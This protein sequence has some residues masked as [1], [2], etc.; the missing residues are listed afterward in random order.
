[1]ASNKYRYPPAPPN[2]DGTFSDNL[3]GFQVVDGGGLTQGNFEFTS[4][5]VQK[6]NRKFETGV[7]QKPLSLSDLNINS[8]L[9]AKRLVAKN[10]KVF[11][12]FDVSEVTS[13]ALYGSLQKRLSTS[14]TKIINYFP[15]AL[16]IDEIG[17]DLSTGY[18]A[19]DILFDNVENTTTFKIDVNRFKNPFDIDYSENADRNIELRPYEVSKYRN[20]TKNYLDYA[21]YFKEFSEEYKF[22][23]FNASSSLYSS[24]VEIT[25]N[26]NPFSGQTTSTDTILL[27]P[28]NQNTQYSFSEYFDEVENFLLSRKNTPIYTA[29]FQV[30]K[31]NENGKLYNSTESV[32]FPKDGYWNLDIVTERF[33]RYIVKLNQISEELDNF[34]TNLISRFLVT[35]SFK[36]FDTQDQR[37]ESVLQL[38]GR[39]FDETKKFIDALANMNSVNYITGND[40]PSQLLKNLAQTLG[41]DINISPITNEGFLKSVFGDGDNS[42]YS[43]V[44]VE[45]TPS[46][47]NFQYYQNLILNSAYLFKSKGTRRSIESLLRMIGAP[48]ALIEFN[49]TIYMADGPINME[50]FNDEFVTITGGTQVIETPAL[51]PSVTFSIYGN[52]YTGFTTNLTLLNVNTNRNDYPLDEQGY[53][54]IYNQNNDFFFQKGAGWYEQTNDHRSSLILN[55]TNSTFTGQNP[56]IQTEFAPFTYGED[57]LNRFREFPFLNMGY[58]LTRILDNKKSWLD[59]N[60]GLRRNTNGGYNAYYTVY[61]ER[62]IL[63]TKNVD[64]GLNMGQ[65]V[66][67]DLYN[68]SVKYN[69]PIP[70][71]GLT[72][73]YP[74]PEGLDWTLINPKPKEKTFFEFAQTF[75]KNMI[76]VRNRQTIN[77]GKGG[78]Y[79]TLQSLYWKYLQSDSAIGIPSNKYTYQKM[80]DFTNGMGDYW[81]KLVEQMIPATT[82]WMGGQKMQNNVLQRQKVVWRRQRG[83]EIIPIPCVPCSYNGNLFSYDCVKQR[84]ECDIA[85][86]NP[87][88]VLTEAIN[89]TITNQGYQVSDCLLNTLSTQ[90]YV[91]IVLDGTVLY[92]DVFYNGNGQNDYPSQNEWID[93]VENTL[94][95]IYQYNLQHSLNDTILTVYNIGCEDLFSDSTL[96]VN[97]KINVDLVCE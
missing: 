13:F 55:E 67:Y 83:C 16:Q 52:I 37:V 32:T 25:V 22:V 40:I 31:E 15:A 80:I 39:S 53:P 2:G 8:V 24:Y 46:E 70:S 14:V 26:G 7:F 23:D 1:M 49:E 5:V 27:R 38:Y 62:L 41:W 35:S 17:P 77:D 74:Y 86:S 73:P 72:S 93:A 28:N 68:M 29:K 18:T 66:L 12:N 43:G 96:E 79:P 54:K 88:S 91:N 6:S 71:T 47:I 10:F 65:G 64:L 56:D 51:D 59:N 61:D 60:T 20:I 76:N 78:G 95:Y 94:T 92:N 33:E 63:N 48:K 58:G 11:P 69:Y 85:I 44:G 84:I 57:Y 45:K 4:G 42:K 87:Q 36:D 75:Y 89:T 81:M 19:Y 21:L 82:I 34:K 50:K 3:V 97:I 90:W 9:E 30:I